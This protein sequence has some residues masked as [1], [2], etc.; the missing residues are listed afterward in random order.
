MAQLIRGGAAA[1][2]EGTVIQV[3]VPGYPPVQ[4]VYPGLAG[5]QEPA[6]VRPRGSV[7]RSLAQSSRSPALG[8]VARAAAEHGIPHTP[9][10]V[11]ANSPH[12]TF[13]AQ[14]PRAVVA[15]AA[16]AAGSGSGS[17][18]W[19]SGSG[20]SGAPA[21]ATA[22]P[23]DRHQRPADPQ[24]QGDRHQRPA[25]PPM[26]PMTPMT[27]MVPYRQRPADSRLAP[28]TPRACPYGKRP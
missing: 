16:A 20:G 6:Q 23:G 4:I 7:A 12:G 21:T 11:V 5:T 14:P 3:A 9:P 1:M 19:S 28:M 26:A 2:P 22:R 15:T 17:F 27:P 24:R 25:D 18:P 13:R 8:G 10:A